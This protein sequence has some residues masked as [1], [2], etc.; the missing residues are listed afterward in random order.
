MLLFFCPL[1]VR[2]RGRK[3]SLKSRREQCLKVTSRKTGRRVAGALPAR[4]LDG[5]AHKA[6]GRAGGREFGVRSHGAGLLEAQ[7]SGERRLGNDG[8]SGP[9][10]PSPEPPDPPP[11]RARDP[12]PSPRP[13]A[14]LAPRRRGR[15]APHP[16]GCPR[17]RTPGANQTNNASPT[18]LL[19]LPADRLASSHLGRSRPERRISAGAERTRATS[20]AT[21]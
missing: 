7:P 4:P 6:G 15:P 10:A 8:C 3:T 18:A 1:S 21:W 5:G 16:T 17:P 2:K 12:P 9:A 14:A 13:P 20:G 11:P 19:P